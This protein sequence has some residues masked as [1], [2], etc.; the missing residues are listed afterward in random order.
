MAK[1]RLYQCSA[2]NEAQ[3]GNNLAVVK[4]ERGKIL[5]CMKHSGRHRAATPD[6]LV[7]FEEFELHREPL[8][9]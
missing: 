6:E 9:E 8:P 4:S 3:T 2:C 5:I 1:Q 7:E